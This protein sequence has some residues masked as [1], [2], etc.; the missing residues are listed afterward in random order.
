M[1]IRILILLLLVS[2]FFLGG[3][4]KDDSPTE[5]ISYSMTGNWDV[6]LQGNGNTE[7]AIWELT[8]NNGLLSG[9]MTLYQSKQYFSGTITNQNIVAMSGND[10]EYLYK[11]NGSANET[12]SNFNGQMEIK[13]T[14][15]TGGV[16]NMTAIKR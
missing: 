13:K 9:S 1:N 2:T 3:C 8:E 16:I 11:I 15:G 6:T 4:S 5:P 12:K 14:D 7:T 10:S